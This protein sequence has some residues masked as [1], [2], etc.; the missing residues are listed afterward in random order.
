MFILI[1]TYWPYFIS[2][3][4]S[5]II[6]FFLKCMSFRSFYNESSCS[7]FSVCDYL[8]QFFASL[9]F[10]DSL[11]C[12][13]FKIVSYLILVG[14]YECIWFSLLF[15]RIQLSASHSFPDNLLVLLDY[16]QCLF[17]KF[18]F[19]LICLEMDFFLYIFFEIL[20]ALQSMH[21]VFN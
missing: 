12:L 8:K 3:L 5:E 21:C 19:T 9:L 2:D 14:W 16:F 20:W 6:S 1:F 10:K 13:E 7:K 18:V 4:L 11:S 17:F 15:L